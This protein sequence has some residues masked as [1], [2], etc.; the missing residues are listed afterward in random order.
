MAP[1][2]RCS[3]EL[4][5]V[6]PAHH[7]LAPLVRRF[8]LVL[9]LESGHAGDGVLECWSTAPI[10]NCTPRPR[11]WECFQ[12]APYFEIQPRVKTLG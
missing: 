1:D 11:G 7:F 5:R 2:R 6:N 9:V 8:V 12:G 10:G 3:V 4:P